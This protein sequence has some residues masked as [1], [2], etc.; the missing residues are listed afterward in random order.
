ML[1]LRSAE[2]QKTLKGTKW[3][4]WKFKALINTDL[5]KMNRRQKE[6]RYRTL[7]LLFSYIYLF[8]N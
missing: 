5:L 1:Y 3:K 2:K 8:K 4:K 6:N 7:L